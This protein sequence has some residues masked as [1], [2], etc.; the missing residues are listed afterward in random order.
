MMEIG[1]PRSPY[2]AVRSKATSTSAA[3]VSHRLQHLVDHQASSEPCEGQAGRHEGMSGDLG[4]CADVMSR[5]R[6]VTAGEWMENANS[7]K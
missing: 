3:A 6:L 2:P 5:Y 1:G 4:V 7:P